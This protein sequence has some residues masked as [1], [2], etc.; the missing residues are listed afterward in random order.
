M[1]AAVVCT[2]LIVLAIGGFRYFEQWLLFPAPPPPAQA[3]QAGPALA[4]TWL[5]SAGDRVEAFLLLPELP[6]GAR[7]PL[8]IHAHGNG[9]LVDYWLPEL[10]PLT[11]RGIAVL[12]VEYPGYGR[13]SGTPSEDSIQRAFAAGYDWAVANPRIDPSRVVGYG[14]S[15]GG[16]AI[17]ALARVRPLAALILESTFTGVRDFLA[18]RASPVVALRSL[19]HNGFD[20]LEVLRDYRAP[21]LV[22]HGERDTMI[23]AAHARELAQAARS[24]ELLLVDCRHNDCP[25]QWPAVLGFL[26][27][28]QLL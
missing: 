3:P 25:R 2:V 18:A 9:E 5:E 15:L 28:H 6:P 8:V 14:W 12:L 11:E 4:Q 23:P 24:S 13:S 1:T 19:A 7:A 26:R 21:V 16:G 17:C 20:N 27:K 10:T 22:I